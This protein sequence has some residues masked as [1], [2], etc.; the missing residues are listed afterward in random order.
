MNY[1]KG[2]PSILNFLLSTSNSMLWSTVLNATLKSMIIIA[3][4]HLC[5]I[6]L[7]ISLVTLSSEVLQ[8]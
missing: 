2:V 3:V 7:S 4:T 5:S 8:L 1:C 6:A